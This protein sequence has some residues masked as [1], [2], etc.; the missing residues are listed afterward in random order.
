MNAPNMIRDARERLAAAERNQMEA[1]RQVELATDE[2]VKAKALYWD[3][4]LTTDEFQM[5]ALMLTVAINAMAMSR[6][7][8]KSCEE[9][10]DKLA[11]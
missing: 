10:Y 9:D 6:T 7:Y 3:G 1:E 5:R 2:V 8:Y 11:K 4:A